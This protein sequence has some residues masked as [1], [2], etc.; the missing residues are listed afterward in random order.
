[1]KLFKSILFTLL[2]LSI[3]TNISLA[4]NKCPG[5][6]A[7]LRW[8]SANC[9]TAFEPSATANQ[10]QF[11]AIAN[12]S[13]SKNIVAGNAV[14]SFCTVTLSCK[15]NQGT[16]ASSQA[17]LVVADGPQ[18]CSALGT[19]LTEGR[20]IWRTGT[21]VAGAKYEKS[22]CY[23]Y[24]P[25]V[26]TAT[27]TPT[28]T[29][30]NTT[31]ATTAPTVKWDCESPAT[32]YSI[33]RTP[34]WASAPAW[35]S[36]T[37]TSTST[38][39]EGS[40]S[41]TDTVA[42]DVE[43][44]YDYTLTCRGATNNTNSAIDTAVTALGTATTTILVPAKVNITNV[45][46]TES[47]VGGD[48]TI[49]WASTGDSCDVYD[50]NTPAVKINSS[51]ILAATTTA[52]GIYASGTLNSKFSF[53][54]S[55]DAPMSRTEL[56]TSHIKSA[57]LG[58]TIICKDST[59]AIRTTDTKDAVVTVFKKPVTS[60][61]GPAANGSFTL[62]CKQD[63]NY[64]DVTKTVAGVTTRVG[65]VTG[66]NNG[67]DYSMT[68]ANPSNSAF[69]LEIK[70]GLKNVYAISTVYPYNALS[71]SGTLIP[72]T[73][74]ESSKTV[75]LNDVEY[76]YATTTDD[77][78]KQLR[79]DINNQNSWTVDVWPF[80]SSSP[81]SASSF[82][83]TSANAG[84]LPAKYK[85]NASGTV[86]L[87]RSASTGYPDGL[88]IKVTATN[89]SSTKTLWI[90]LVNSEK[91]LATLTATASSTAADTYR[92]SAVCSNSSA[93]ELYQDPSTT[94]TATGSTNNVT[95]FSFSGDILATSTDQNATTVNIKLVCISG[96][97]SPQRSTSTAVLNIGSRSLVKFHS[98]S[99]Q[100]AA[101]TCPGGN[102]EAAVKFD[103]SNS[104]GKICKIKATSP[105]NS[106]NTDILLQMSKINELLGSTVYDSKV[107][108]GPQNVSMTSVM[109]KLDDNLHNIAVA[110]LKLDNATGKLDNGKRLFNYSTRFTIECGAPSAAGSNTPVTSGPTYSTKF[111]DIMASC[112][113]Q[114]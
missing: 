102:T 46:D 90:I 19:A 80:A 37:T 3:F 40:A 74:L 82:S 79:Y 18:C 69:V 2:T 34:A 87:D 8:S 6:P 91:P 88:T 86:D 89:A 68:V 31:P 5:A 63:F 97:M 99:V 78:F 38:G 59:R 33:V 67:N 47:V 24:T 14:G 98:L 108:G 7:I 48:A 16:T 45:S 85:P 61:T 109:S 39:L 105:N 112:A 72:G 29:A 70:C 60:I 32:S 93:W 65:G 41:D 107:S 23:K 94:P 106:T 57:A 84:N 30:P 49:T 95:P 15:G 114:N 62:S 26:I 44:R 25:P 12:T 42:K 101:I 104:S 71:I 110:T 92:L 81:A 56:N 113:S 76:I 17:E 20:N 73:G 66:N 9:S 111:V 27:T 4:V 103:I 51:P 13:G 36:G 35:A 21:G 1:M 100:P 53:T 22:Q 54:L 28:T 58:Y 10:C 64:V 96:G 50:K 75:L 55:P 83:G 11:E 52:G 77:N 43:T